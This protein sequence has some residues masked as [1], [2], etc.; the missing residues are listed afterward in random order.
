MCK[1]AIIPGITDKTTVDAWK[2]MKQLSKDMSISDNDGF[3]YAAVDGAGKMFG[4]RWFINKEAFMFRSKGPAPDVDFEK[5][6]K[7]FLKVK[8]STES[9]KGE[10][11]NNFGELHEDSL[12]CAILHARTATCEKNLDNTHPFVIGSFALVHNGIIRNTEEL[13]NKISTCDSE[14]ILQEYI[15][16]DVVNDLKNIQAMADKLEGSYACGVIAKQADGRLIVD[17]M[18]D[19]SS[20]LHGYFIKE[21]NSVVFGTTSGYSDGYGPIPSACR[22]LK[23]SIT[24]D[25]EIPDHRVIRIDVMTG[26]VLESM[27]FDSTY[28]GKRNRGGSTN[29]TRHLGIVGDGDVYTMRERIFGAA[30]GMR[31][32]EHKNRHQHFND[33]QKELELERC[34][35]EGPHNLRS[36]HEGYEVYGEKTLPPIPGTLEEKKKLYET[37]WRCDNDGLWHKKASGMK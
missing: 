4:E 5:I 15:K 26:E 32:R 21:L 36:N 3:G 13:D 20:R 11:Y 10:T 29:T 9:Y 6:Y 24:K 1:I 28:K 25:F 37:E 8:G 19:R 12:R 30:A 16:H 17:I 34:L 33:H 2:L 18:R 22:D 23:F 35:I 27:D 31:S 7:G 14:C